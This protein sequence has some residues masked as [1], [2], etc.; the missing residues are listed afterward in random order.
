MKMKTSN[1]VKMNQKHKFKMLDYENKKIE[2]DEKMV[3][4]MMKLWSLN[5]KTF[6]CCQQIPT[7]CVMMKFLKFKEKYAYIGVSSYKDRIRLLKYITSKGKSCQVFKKYVYI[8]T[9]D[10]GVFT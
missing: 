2:I 6:A 8:K 1:K 7:D 5:I 4:L 10:L 3:P 9:D